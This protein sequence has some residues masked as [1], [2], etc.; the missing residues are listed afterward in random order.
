GGATG[1]APGSGGFLPNPNAP[2]T[3]AAQPAPAGQ[4]AAAA[5]AQPQ[6][7]PATPAAG[8]ARGAG[9]AGQPAAAAGRQGGARGQ[10][11]AVDPDD[12]SEVIVAGLVGSGGGGLT[13]LVFAAREGDIDSAKMLL[14]AGADVNQQTEYGWTPLLVATNN[15]FYKLASYLLE[16]GAD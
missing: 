16:R 15:R 14:D 8:R 7:A 5:P 12:D 13:P 3:G 4:P 2:P 11:A 1:L 10:G 9:P 6:P